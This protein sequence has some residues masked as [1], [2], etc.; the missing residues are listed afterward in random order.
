MEYP[1]VVMAAGSSMSLARDDVG[2]TNSV[3]R[4]T[5]MVISGQ[6]EN[7]AMLCCD[8]HKNPY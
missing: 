1:A 5:M 2:I 6:I 7:L 3:Q 8:L 4:P